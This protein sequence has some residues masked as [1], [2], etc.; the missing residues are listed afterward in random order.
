MVT[1]ERYP[2]YELT[3]RWQTLQKLSYIMHCK[4]LCLQ[5]I[6]SLNVVGCAE[7]RDPA[8]PG[9]GHGDSQLRGAVQPG[10]QQVSN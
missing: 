1:Y 9:P 4:N 7:R 10:Q 6:A 2:G 3:V 5:C 8:E